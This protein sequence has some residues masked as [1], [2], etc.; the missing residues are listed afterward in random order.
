MYDLSEHVPLV[1]TPSV[2]GTAGA[3]GAGEDHHIWRCQGGQEFWCVWVDA[4]HEAL[5]SECVSMTK[6]VL[7]CS[8][9]WS[10]Q[11]SFCSSY[12]LSSSLPAFQ[13][14]QQVARASL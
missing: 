5:G 6:E 7:G 4:A 12:P 3:A 13:L 9:P 10:L 8:C 14:V 2:L 1:S 11:L